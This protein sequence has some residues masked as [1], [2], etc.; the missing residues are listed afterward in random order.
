[1]LTTNRKVQREE[2]E[3]DLVPTTTTTEA[4]AVQGVGEGRES[5]TI[6]R[7]DRSRR[8]S[9]GCL[10]K[11]ARAGRVATARAIFF[12]IVTSPLHPGI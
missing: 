8:T 3:D 6:K 12:A 7:T 5:R 9:S 2:N 10:R 11:K 4:T 1:M